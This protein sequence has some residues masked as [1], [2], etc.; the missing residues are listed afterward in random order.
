MTRSEVH[1]KLLNRR[2]IFRSNKIPLSV[3]VVPRAFGA[4]SVEDFVVRSEM[5]KLARANHHNYLLKD[6]N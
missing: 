1:M 3:I 5:R 6:A 4:S 2:L